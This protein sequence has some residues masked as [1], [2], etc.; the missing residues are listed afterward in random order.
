VFQEKGVEAVRVGDGQGMARVFEL[1]ILRAGD[2]FRH[3]PAECWFGDAILAAADDKRRNSGEYRKAR[4]GIVAAH[5]VEV[6]HHDRRL[7]REIVAEEIRHRLS[8]RFGRAH[9]FEERFSAPIFWTDAGANT[10]DQHAPGECGDIAPTGKG[11]EQGKA[12]NALRSGAGDVLR[13]QPAHGMAGDVSL[14][15]S[16]GIHKCQRVGGELLNG[17]FAGGGE[18]LADAAIVEAETVMMRCER[19]DLRVPPVAL[20]THALDEQNRYTATSEAIAETAALVL[21]LRHGST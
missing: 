18:A 21:K 9:H 14:L 8:E 10:G 20:D 7:V 5:S 19:L 17:K 4:S 13:N 3:G 2:G 16:G 6:L 1:D 15:P 11:T 12:E